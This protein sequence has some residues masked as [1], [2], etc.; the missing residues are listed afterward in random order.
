MIMDDLPIENIKCLE[1]IPES[2]WNKIYNVI[3][4][5]S[6]DFI[7]SI[8]M[9]KY[10]LTEIERIT[11]YLDKDHYDEAFSFEHFSSEEAGSEFRDF[12]YRE[13]NRD[14]QPTTR[15]VNI[16]CFKPKRLL[17]M[18]DEQFNFQ[19]KKL[20]HSKYLQQKQKEM[21]FD[22]AIAYHGTIQRWRDFAKNKFLCLESETKS[23][24]V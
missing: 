2:L 1:E 13:D 23:I 9:D 7:S 4:G 22:L 21:K 24:L 11:V 10:D 5:K 18:T 6:E 14:W 12:I 16:Y 17:N 19:L 15:Q 3:D 20:K 8:Q